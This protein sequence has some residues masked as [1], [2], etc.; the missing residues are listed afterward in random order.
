MADT[1]AHPQAPAASGV[2]DVNPWPALIALCI[3]FFMI[4]VDSTIVSVAT[5]DIITSLHSDINNGVGDQRLPAG[6]RRPVAHHGPARRPIR[7]Q[8]RV[9]GRPGALHGGLPRMRS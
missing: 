7:S 5:P 1:S 6:V 3:G 8:E 4:L 2:P 9:S